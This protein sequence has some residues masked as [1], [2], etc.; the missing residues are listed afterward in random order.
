[1]PVLTV[2]TLGVPH[3]NTSPVFN[4]EQVIAYEADESNVRCPSLEVETKC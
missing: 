2:A 3:N 4:E 1:M